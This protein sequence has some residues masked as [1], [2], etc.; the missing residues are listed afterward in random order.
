MGYRTQTME[1]EVVFVDTRSREIGAMTIR[2]DSEIEIDT[3]F[4]DVT[5]DEEADG[6]TIL[7]IIPQEETP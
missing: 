1:H 3:E 7:M 4:S 6:V 5:T 2:S